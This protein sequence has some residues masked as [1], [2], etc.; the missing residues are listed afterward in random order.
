MLP[1]PAHRVQSLRQA[2]LSIEETRQI[3]SGKDAVPLL[4]KRRGELMSELTEAFRREL[5]TFTQLAARE[6]D[7]PCTIDDAM[8]TAWTAE[9]ATT[10]AHEKR[11][12]SIE[13]AQARY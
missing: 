4:E 7:S 10:S 12:V 1:F 11:P 5:T 8:G 3:R 2:G 6:I 9:A 13:E